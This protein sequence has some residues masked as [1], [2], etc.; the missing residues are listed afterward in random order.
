MYSE[1]DQKVI[2]LKV[3]ELEK[4]A[5]TMVGGSRVVGQQGVGAGSR[6]SKD[7]GRPGAAS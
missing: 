4:S 5:A 3:Q 7:E 1:T 2:G 6:P